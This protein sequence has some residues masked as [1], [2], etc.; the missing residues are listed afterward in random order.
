MHPLTLTQLL[1]AHH[2]T[3]RYGKN[4]EDPM[5]VYVRTLTLTLIPCSF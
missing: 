5:A 4:K 1:A 3:G 2:L